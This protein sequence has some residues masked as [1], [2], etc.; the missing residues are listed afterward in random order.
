MLTG[1]RCGG[2]APMSSPSSRMRPE[3]GVSNPASIRS[4]VVLPQPEGPSSA[5]NSLC[6][7]SSVTALTAG[8]PPKRLLTSSKR[9]SAGP[10]L[11]AIDSL[12]HADASGQ[13]PRAQ[14]G[15]CGRSDFRRRRFGLNLRRTRM[16][17]HRPVIFAEMDAL[18]RLEQDRQAAVE[19]RLGRDR[20]AQEL[21]DAEFGR[22]G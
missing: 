10:P 9:T 14:R 12:V 18:A 2:T 3:V 7:M 20:L 17:R 4:S 16:P 15:I 11:S 13:A 6:M 8:T 5:K 1:R 22:F 19:Q 21:V